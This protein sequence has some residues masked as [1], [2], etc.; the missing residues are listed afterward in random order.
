MRV[1]GRNCRAAVNDSDYRLPVNQWFDIFRDQLLKCG[2]QGQLPTEAAKRWALANR[3][4]SHPIDQDLTRGS[5][6]KMRCPRCLSEGYRGAT[7]CPVCKA[8]FASQVDTAIYYPTPYF[9]TG[10]HTQRVMVSGVTM[11]MWMTTFDQAGV[12]IDGIGLS[13]CHRSDKASGSGTV[14]TQETATPVFYSKEVAAIF[15]A[16]STFVARLPRVTIEEQE[17]IRYLSEY[18]NSVFKSRVAA[19]YVA[20]DRWLY[21]GGRAEGKGA[22][23]IPS[24]WILDREEELTLLTTPTCVSTDAHLA[25]MTAVAYLTQ[26]KKTL[27]VLTDDK[28]TSQLTGGGTPRSNGDRV[29][30]LPGLTTSSSGCTS[31]RRKPVI[32]E[33]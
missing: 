24:S 27:E 7:S 32:L 10:E 2:Y 23:F 11:T 4:V 9:N 17:V 1:H 29:V 13:S 14:P 3:Y 21:K 19:Q 6:E 33:V 12:P 30:E 20:T 25:A 5:L 26:N 15:E 8:S 31:W 22:G 18:L 28:F 16:N